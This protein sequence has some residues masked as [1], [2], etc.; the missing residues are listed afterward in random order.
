MDYGIQARFTNSSALN[1][2]LHAIRAVNVELDDPSTKDIDPASVLL[3]LSYDNRI[4]IDNT[5][6]LVL[7]GIRDIPSYW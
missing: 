1:A 2:T 5:K 4:T 7:L 6:H 3:V